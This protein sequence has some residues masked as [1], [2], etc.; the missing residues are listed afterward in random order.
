[1][2][3]RGT[4]FGRLWFNFSGALISNKFAYFWMGTIK[5]ALRAGRVIVGEQAGH[6]LGHGLLERVG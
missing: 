5:G 2:H 3:P 4:S 1:M 6:M